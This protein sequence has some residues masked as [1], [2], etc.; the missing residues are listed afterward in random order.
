MS[1]NPLS[2]EN[3]ASLIARAKAMIMQPKAEWS[4]VAAVPGNVQGI[5]IKYALPLI[6]I[7]P[8]CSFIGGQLFGYNAMIMMFRPSLSF[9]L[10]IAITGFVQSIIALF[11]VSFAANFLSPKFGGKD[12]FGSAFKLVAYSMT[13]AWLA[14]VFGILPMLGGIAAIA[15]GIYSIYVLFLGATPVMAVPQEK[16]AG[17]IAVTVLVAIVASIILNMVAASFITPAMAF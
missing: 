5:L 6:A 11:V 14:G 1:D 13:A 9:S 15:G 17:Y 12:D 10:T 4:K 8:I 16:A 7:G 2:S 3:T